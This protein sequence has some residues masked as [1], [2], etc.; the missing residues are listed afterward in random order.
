MN[1]I[2]NPNVEILL[3]SYNG[4]K[5]IGE[6]I[7]SII[8][9]DYSNWSLIIRDDGSS[10]RTVEIIRKYISQ[11]PLKIKL[12][13]DDNRNLGST[14]NFGRLIAQSTS[15]YIMLCDQD[16]VWIP[17]KVSLSIHRI[18]ELEKQNKG[19]PILVFTDLMIV[20][21][22]LELLSKSFWESQKI[23]PARA[24]NYLKYSALNI[25]TGCTMIF[26][27]AAKNAII[28]IPRVNV[29]HDYWIGLNVSY[30]GIIDYIEVKTV[31]YRQHDKNVMGSNQISLKYFFGKSIIF[32]QIFRD[33]LNVFDKLNF[34]I[35]IFAF[36][37]YKTYFSII[38]FIK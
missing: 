22:N 30:Y 24:K 18:L 15:K 12:L 25:I 23:N 6:Q 10:D 36:L 20:D 3:A 7:E 38:R 21:E 17:N 37:C 2:S 5:Y 1:N 4:E 32:I 8:F 27:E 11:F 35:N 29:I 28:P 19:K 16:D 33:Y 34:K 9:Q 14:Q 31:M 13:Y 26:N